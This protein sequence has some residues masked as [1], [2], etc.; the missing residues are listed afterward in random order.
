[1]LVSFKKQLKA[2][3]ENKEA[4]KVKGKLIVVEENFSKDSLKN[5]RIYFDN[6]I[7]KKAE[8]IGYFEIF[9]PNLHFLY[10]GKNTKF[11]L[12]KN[13]FIRKKTKQLKKL[14]SAFLFI[15]F[16]VRKKNKSNVVFF[17]S[18]AHVASVLKYH[19][20]RVEIV[21]IDFHQ[22]FRVNKI[23]LDTLKKSKYEVDHKEN[24]IYIY[25]L[26]SPSLI[27]TIKKFNINSNIFLRF[28]DVIGVNNLS[29]HKEIIFKLSENN[30][31]CGANSYCL[32]EANRLG[33][34][35][36][37]NMVN[38]KKLKTEFS[39]YQIQYKFSFL[40]FEKGR[41]GEI[42]R[43]L[44]EKIF[45]INPQWKESFFSFKAGKNFDV[46]INYK[47]Y[48]KILAESE[49]II[50]I[51]RISPHE[52]LSFRTPE[53]LV[54][55]KKVITD[56]DLRPFKFYHES[57]FFTL[58]VDKFEDLEDFIISPFLPLKE[59]ELKEIDNTNFF[60]SIQWAIDLKSLNS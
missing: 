18:S 31:I 59:K 55:N 14:I 13:F 25:N 45:F 60:E 2:Y 26:L 46:I 52:G 24:S 7:F 37:P 48:L 28:H 32:N 16:F 42:L 6:I 15:D 29:N 11:N 8:E 17:V 21:S 33:I 49:I 43:K 58:G 19:F 41:R 53:C 30:I 5:A 50:D 47:D 54:L 40:A 35:Y 9:S 38:V 22:L 34:K 57:R 20:P 12:L 1:M 39:E 3:M 36:L 23:I 51:S 10:E 27:S 4:F 56:R 44:K